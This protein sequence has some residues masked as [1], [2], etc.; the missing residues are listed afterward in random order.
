MRQLLIVKA[1]TSFGSAASPIDNGLTSH[2]VQDLSGLKAGAISFFELGEA[3]SKYE[4]MPTKNFAIALGRKNNQH[5]F[6]I[7]EVDINT[8]TVTKALPYAGKVFSVVFTMPTTEKGKEYTLRFFKKGVVPHE[9]NSWTVS[10]VASNTTAG[11]QATAF[12]AAMDAKVND[13]FQFTTT[14]STAQVTITGVVGEDWEVVAADSLASTSLTITHAEKAIGDK[15]FVQDLASR[16]AYGKGFADTY[17]N[18]DTTIPGYPEDVEDFTLN[19]S[20][21]NRN[22]SNTNNGKYSTSGYAIYTLRFKVGRVA[23][24]Q[25]DE[26]VWQEVYIAIPI[27][28][29][30]TYNQITNLDKILPAGDFSANYAKAIADAEIRT[31]VKSASLES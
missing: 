8:L 30:S 22:G 15:A 1:P 9:R 7:P 13:K 28:S 17:R 3:L 23:S 25:R 6:I 20:G 26:R 5:P 11:D 29:N 4:S 31:L 18:G 19:D 27:D 14:L 16:C 12:K 10:I 21:S 2:D 24:K